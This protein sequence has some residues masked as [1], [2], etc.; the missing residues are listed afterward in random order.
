[1][2]INHS[3]MA[4]VLKAHVEHKDG[5]L[6]KLWCQFCDHSDKPFIFDWALET[7]QAGFRD[8]RKER[9]EVSRAG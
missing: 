6:L 3:D 9:R 2:D 5:P 4:Q 8:G 7:Y 1:M